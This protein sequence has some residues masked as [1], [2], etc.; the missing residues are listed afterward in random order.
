MSQV[1]YSSRKVFFMMFAASLL[2]FLSVLSV[3]TTFALNPY[4]AAEAK[5]FQTDKWFE[6][7]PGEVAWYAL[8][9]DPETEIDEDTKDITLQSISVWMD[10]EP[11]EQ[12][13]NF[14]VWTEDQL[15][16]LRSEDGDTNEAPALG[17][18]SANDNTP[19]DY[20]WTGEYYRGTT[21]YI[22]VEN[23]SHETKY[24][25]LSTGD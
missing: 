25:S 1:L 23:T 20:F 7:Q 18:G 6:L 24:Y 13:I 3:G 5:L 19:G 17:A 12:G 22:V 9:Y 16:E 10:T 8:D 2:L 15:K 11:S 14:T 4:E 21:L